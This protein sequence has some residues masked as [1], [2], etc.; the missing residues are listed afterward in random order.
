[1]CLNEG[2]DDALNPPP[3]SPPLCGGML[4]TVGTPPDPSVPDVAPPDAFPN[5]AEFPLNNMSLANMVFQTPPTLTN[6]VFMCFHAPDTLTK[7][8]SKDFH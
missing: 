4:E 1:L 3:P 8:E 7:M 2:F 5:C 6:P